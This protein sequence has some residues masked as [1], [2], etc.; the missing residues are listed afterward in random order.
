MLGK[1]PWVRNTTTTIVPEKIK[2]IHNW[3]IPSSLLRA[4]GQEATAG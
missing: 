4:D 2:D 3:Q 1:L